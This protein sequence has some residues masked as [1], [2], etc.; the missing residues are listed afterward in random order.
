MILKTRHGVFP[1]FYHQHH[2]M[3]TLSPAS[4]VPT[5]APLR[6]DT[7]N[8]D[9]LINKE[10]ETTSTSAPI[11]MT[12]TIP[13]VVL[14]TDVVSDNMAARLCT[15]FLGHVLFLKNQ[16]PLSVLSLVF[17]LFLCGNM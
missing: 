17:P 14:D 9:S 3:R 8:A 12:S 10:K 2:L 7:K 13:T 11:T 6:H 4:D 15:S 5:L 1:R 16:V